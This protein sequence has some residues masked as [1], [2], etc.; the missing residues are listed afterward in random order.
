MVGKAQQLQYYCLY[1]NTTSITTIILPV[2]QYYW[3]YYNTTSVTTILLA[4]LLTCLWV[5]LVVVEDD[6]GPQTTV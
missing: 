3:L 6:T 5:E 1:Y 2:L 4:V